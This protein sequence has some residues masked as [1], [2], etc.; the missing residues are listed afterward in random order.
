VRLYDM[1]KGEWREG[2]FGRG[3]SWRSKQVYRCEVC[4]TRTNLWVIGGYP[5]GV[6][7]A[8]LLCPARIYKEHQELQRLHDRHRKT[9][10]RTS[11]LRRIFKS[12]KNLDRERVSITMKC[13]EGELQLLQARINELRD[14]FSGR[15][16]DI[17]GM[18]SNGELVDFHP[19]TRVVNPDLSILDPQIGD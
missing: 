13:L 9:A 12:A 2:D 16:D 3:D 18:E 19:S 6:G 8:R 4:H 11:Y 1:E 7:G 17:E 5:M 15:C 10:N 14:A